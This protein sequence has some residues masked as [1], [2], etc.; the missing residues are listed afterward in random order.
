[1]GSWTRRFDDG[2]PYLAMVTMQLS[3]AVMSIIAKCALNHG[4]SPH[5]LVAYRLAVASVL[6]APFAFVLERKSR[7]KLT[8][9][10]F[11]KIMLISLL[12][13]V[14]DHTFYYTGM[15]YTTATFTAAMC[16]VLPAITFA[17][18]WIFRLERVEIGRVRS[19]MKVAGTVVTVGGAMLM[20]LIKGPIL[21]L[22]WTKGQNHHSGRSG[23]SRAHKQDLVIGALMLIA[24]CCCWATFIISQAS[25]LKSYPAKLSLTA[26]ICI[27]G[28]VEGTV[29]ALAMEW[30]N[31]SVWRIKL[32]TKLTAAVYGGMVT[33]F[34]LY[35]MGSVMKKRG[36][37]FVSAF[38]P[39]GMVIVAVLGSIFLAE[40]MYLGRVIG[41]IV[42]VIGLY[43]VLWGKSKERAQPTPEGTVA[44]ADRQMDTINGCIE[45]PDPE[46]ITIEK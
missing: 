23:T 9:A 18:A 33:A 2:K 39:L 44:P 1:M 14:L 38:N 11:F 24:G 43:L 42:I 27:T 19:L 30:H 12:E 26:L 21:D 36:P 29:L 32:D 16:N 41:S 8:S 34:A 4:M 35:T 20:T 7:P 17:L 6:I 45:N 46:P 5:V 31:T 25:I 10:I 22:P 13:P 40:E 15:K 37:V 28:T 3:Y